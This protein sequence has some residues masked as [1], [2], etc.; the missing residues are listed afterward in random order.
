MQLYK[1]NKL[2]NI[3]EKNDE[4]IFQKT[5]KDFAQLKSLFI[6]YNWSREIPEQILNECFKSLKFQKERTLH[7]ELRFLKKFFEIKD[8]EQFHILR[9]EYYIEEYYL[10][11]EI[12]ST[13]KG[14]IYFI[15]ELEIDKTDFYEVLV[16]IKEFLSKNKNSSYDILEN[17]EQSL[18]KY[19]INISKL[20][21]E[22]EDYLNI[23]QSLYKNNI[24]IKL[25]IKLNDTDIKTLQSHFSN[26][27]IQDIINCSKF[28]H[29]LSEEKGKI[30]DKKLIENFIKKVSETKNISQNFLNYSSIAKQ[31]EEFLA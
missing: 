20:K 30:N 15:D 23:L 24:S 16:K 2:K 29:D 9:L 7:H 10:L 25:L 27:E 17:A 1:V 21:E 19:G 14:C 13:T 22:K 5:E 31:V 4:E 6:S 12:I 11:K 28:I 3:H 26:Q 8:F 18:K